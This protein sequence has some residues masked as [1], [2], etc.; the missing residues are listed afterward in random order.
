[1]I[2]LEKTYLLKFVPD[3]LH[4]C[5]NKEI[6]DIYIPKIREH[7]TLRIRKDGN[8]FEVTKK[9]PV[10]DDASKQMEQTIQ[11]LEEEFTEFQKLDGKVVSKR[12][13][14]YR[15]YNKIA[16]VDVFQ[17]ELKGLVLIDFE[18]D[19]EKEK[20]EFEMPDF[21]LADVTH[22]LFLAGGMLCGKSYEDIENDLKRF[23]Y[24]KIIV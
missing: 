12:R 23:D 1:M 5:E 22:E 4:N 10:T 13:Y 15:Y 7:P 2:E 20:D 8:K 16:E 17:G 3:G 19:T 9:E 14:L 18:F 11:L 6:I 24:Q 21:C